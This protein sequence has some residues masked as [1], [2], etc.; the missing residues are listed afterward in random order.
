M[1]HANC[2]CPRRAPPCARWSAPVA[3][4]FPV[5]AN[6]APVISLFGTNLF[7]VSLPVP[8]PGFLPQ[9]VGKA[10]LSA[11]RRAQTRA[12]FPANRENSCHDD[13]LSGVVAMRIAH[14]LDDFH[15]QWRAPPAPAGCFPVDREK[16]VQSARER[17]RVRRA[18]SAAH[19]STSTPF[20]AHHSRSAF[21]FASASYSYQLSRAPTRTRKSLNLR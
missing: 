17:P 20:S 21:S 1:G 8:I 19:P 2:A 5:I 11:K 9:V 7:P 6:I 16:T 10:A 18:A 13:S 12:I 14:A 3:R 4:W 15:P